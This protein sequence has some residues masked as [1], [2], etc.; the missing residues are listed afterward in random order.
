M[1]GGKSVTRGE[2]VCVGGGEEC[3]KRREGVCWGEECD[4]RREGVCGGEECAYGKVRVC[5]CSAC[6]SPVQVHK[7]TMDMH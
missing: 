5:D 2:R 6:V 3:D 1:G 4:K 7:R